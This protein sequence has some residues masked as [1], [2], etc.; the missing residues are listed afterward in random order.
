MR[1]PKVAIL[2]TT[3]LQLAAFRNRVICGAFMLLA[4]LPTGARGNQGGR[5]EQRAVSCTELDLSQ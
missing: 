3:I 5:E 1:A 4:P 2:T